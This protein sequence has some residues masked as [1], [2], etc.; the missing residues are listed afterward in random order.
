VST[1]H[2]TT[3]QEHPRRLLGLPYDLRRPTATRSRARAWNP[4]D[5]RI[6]T[7]KTFGW[8]FGLNFYWLLHPLRLVRARRRP[9]RAGLRGADDREVLS[10]GLVALVA[11]FGP[12]RPAPTGRSWW[13]TWR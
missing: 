11:P 10:I 3:R 5:P 7:P 8:G 13:R 12:P 2:D 9:R 6:L 1:Q 4:D